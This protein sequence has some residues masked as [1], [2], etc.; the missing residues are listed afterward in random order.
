M[1]DEF[2]QEVIR[3]AIEWCRSHGHYEALR[4]YPITDVHI[5]LGRLSSVDDFELYKYPTAPLDSSE[6]IDAVVD[7][8][9]NFI[10]DLEEHIRTGSGGGLCVLLYK[11]IVAIQ[12]TR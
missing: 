4:T 7:K 11:M 12:S 3:H 10:W 9:L 5:R 8:N 2:S 1:S 6:Q